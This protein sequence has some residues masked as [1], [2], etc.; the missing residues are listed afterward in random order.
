V[1]AKPLFYLRRLPLNPTV[2]RGMINVHVPFAYRLLEIT[3]ADP[4]PAVPTR[5]PKDDLVFKLTLLELAELAQVWKLD[6]VDDHGALL[7]HSLDRFIHDAVGIGISSRELPYDSNALAPKPIWI[8]AF[9]IITRVSIG[10]PCCRIARVTPRNDTEHGGGIRY[11][12]CYRASR[13]LT[14]A[15]RH[16]SEAADQAQFRLNTN[17]AVHRGGT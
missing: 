10:L 11:R 9:P 14:W 5:R 13:I 16:K 4:I 15:E 8:K 6:R 17:N 3:V 1:P 2:D 12:A 7:F